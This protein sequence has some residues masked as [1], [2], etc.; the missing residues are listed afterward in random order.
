[1][2][3]TIEEIG[4]IIKA[5]IIGEAP[6]TGILRI[7][8][9][10]RSLSFPDETLFFAIVTQHGDGHNYIDGLYTRGVRS[11]VVNG[12]FDSGRYPDACF[13]TVKDTDIPVRYFSEGDG[14]L[15]TAYIKADTIT[16]SSTSIFATRTA[17]WVPY[18]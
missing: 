5:E 14:A 10:S 3:Y 17:R 9:D 6:E 15:G 11:F 12:T 7:L 13:L 18:S 16:H 2:L 4:K 8:T 1:M